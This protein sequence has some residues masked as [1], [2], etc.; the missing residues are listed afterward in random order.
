MGRSRTLPRRLRRTRRAHGYETASPRG[1]RHLLRGGGRSV[2][3]R[4]RRPCRGG[5]G[6]P[7]L[8]RGPVRAG[9]GLPRSH[10][11][12]AR[13]GAS[14]PIR[15]Q[16]ESGGRNRG[17]DSYAVPCRNAQ[18][19]EDLFETVAAALEPGRQL[20]VC[21][22]LCFFFIDGEAW[23]VCGDLEE[24]AARFAEVDRTEV[25]PVKHGRHA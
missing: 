5:R 20:E 19:R 1:R 11:C 3:L 7:R 24:D 9:S 15:R 14:V 8:G 16:A 13:G 12:R 4:T 23:G 17:P 6:W 2:K 21:A 10:P 18:R 25:V 22:E